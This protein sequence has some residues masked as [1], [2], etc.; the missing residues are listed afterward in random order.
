VKKSDGFPTLAQMRDA[1]VHNLSDP[2]FDN[3][4]N[5][6]KE[7]KRIESMVALADLTRAGFIKRAAG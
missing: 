2:F 4:P 7:K 5:D 6:T 3:G 1:V